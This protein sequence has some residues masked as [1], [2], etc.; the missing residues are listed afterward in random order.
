APFPGSILGHGNRGPSSRSQRG[1]CAVP[2]LWWP[3]PPDRRALQTLQDRSQRVPCPAAAGSSAVTRAR[4][5]ARTAATASAGA[6]RD[7]SAARA[8][9]QRQR[10]FG[11]A[12]AVAV[13]ATVGAPAV[14]GAEPAADQP[15]AARAGS[16]AADLATAAVGDV[17]DTHATASA[18]ALGVAE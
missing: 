18:A 10:T 9:T 5:A 8:G 12:G 6:G 3:H 14:S 13:G 4:A 2:G 16:G 15:G 7:P 17:V 11:I 1:T